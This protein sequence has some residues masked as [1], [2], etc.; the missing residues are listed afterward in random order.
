MSEILLV[1]PPDILYN[2]TPSILLVNPSPQVREDIQTILKDYD[3]DINV[4]L[5]DMMPPDEDPAWLTQVASIADLIVVDID[6]CFGET[7][8]M[9]SYLLGK[10]N[11]YYLTKEGFVPYTMISRNVIDSIKD[12]STLFERG[13]NEKSKK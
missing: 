13:L 6:Y 3:K 5:Y 11:T 8:L 10:P 7:K 9:V 2:N 4:Y 1:T 12:I